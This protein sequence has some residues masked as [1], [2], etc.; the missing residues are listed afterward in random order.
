MSLEMNLNVIEEHLEQLQAINTI[1][2]Y[3][4]NWL[5][6]GKNVSEMK[7]ESLE[8]ALRKIKIVKEM[9]GNKRAL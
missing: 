7:K 8:I 9:C 3:D 5:A 4:R 2:Y 1:E 6:S